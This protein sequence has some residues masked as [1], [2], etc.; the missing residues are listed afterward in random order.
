MPINFQAALGVHEQALKLRSQR[1]EVLANNIANADTPGYKAK[2]LDFKSI[3]SAQSGSSENLRL[4][5][6]KHMSTDFN[7]SGEPELLFRNPNQPS[8]DGNTV[9]VHQE[10]AEYLRN[11]LEFQTSFRF[12]NGKLKG[13]KAAIRGD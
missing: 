3:L 13:M 10:K 8:V 12:L 6:N 11:S 5:H 9:E 1:A 4:T 7:D 2:D